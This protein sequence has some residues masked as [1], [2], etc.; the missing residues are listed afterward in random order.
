MKTIDVG[1]VMHITGFLRD[2]CVCVA[3]VAK[4]AALGLACAAGKIPRPES[5]SIVNENQVRD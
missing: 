5:R 4:F 1:K 3:V 2:S